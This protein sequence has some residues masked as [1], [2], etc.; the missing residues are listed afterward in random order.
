MKLY[1]ITILLF[2]SNIVFT[3]N[4]LDSLFNLFQKPNYREVLQA[5]K[6]II[7]HQKEAIPKLIEFLTDISFVKL[8]NTGDLT[9]PG[10]TYFSTHSNNISYD[11]DWI[12]IRS[13]WILEELT[14]QDFGYVYIKINEDD[15]NRYY[16]QK[17]KSNAIGSQHILEFKNK[18]LQEQTLIYRTI[19]AD[20]VSIWWENHNETW[21]R[22]DAIKD[23]LLSDNTNRQYLALEYIRSGETYCENL[24]ISNYDKEIKP[25]LKKLKKSNDKHNGLAKYILKDK[26]HHWY[27]IK[28]ATINNQ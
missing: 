20:K 16:T 21:T 26:E 7:N 28:S 12:S 17:Y 4:Q 5:K 22:I 8:I 2:T 11:I 18:S 1:L 3:Q 19:L 6:N 10:S 13:A 15:L 24:T 23:A 27:K 14:F 25:I 9:Y